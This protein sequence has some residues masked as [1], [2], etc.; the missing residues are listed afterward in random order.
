MNE[1]IYGN[2]RIPF[3]LVRSNRKTLETRV[4]PDGSVEVRAP[5]DLDIKKVLEIVNKRGR[6]VVKKRLHFRQ[7]PKEDLNKRY[8]SGETHRY[9][10][11]QYRL[12][13]I[14][15]ETINVKMK[16]RFIEVH[17][18]DRSPEMVELLLYDWYRHHARIKFNEILDEAMKVVTKHGIKRPEMKIKRMKKRW[19]SCVHGKNRI[20]LN[21]ELIRTP[22]YCIE[23]VIFHELVHL[24]VPNHQKEYYRLLDQVLPSWKE[25]KT[26]LELYQIA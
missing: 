9:L 5:E 4:K 23:Y 16:G 8:V 12:K 17:T 26:K 7:Y 20:H 22:S 6:W 13:V 2:Q 10:G 21:L 24:K 15:S 19:G 3:K 11:R 25:Y 18:R 14:E 1:I